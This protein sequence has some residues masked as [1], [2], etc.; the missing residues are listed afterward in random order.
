MARFEKHIFVCTNQRPP[1]HPRGCCFDKG[2]MEIRAAFVRGLAQRGLKG[3]VRANKSGC[4]DACEMGATVL[5]YPRGTW[6]LGVRLEDVE[7]IM[8]TSIVGEGVVE[9]LAARPDEWER[10]RQLRKRSTT[11]ATAA[12]GRDK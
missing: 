6:Y 8:E 5:I 10:L 4:L 3:Q 1:G 7:E 11:T 12:A 2:S 9:R